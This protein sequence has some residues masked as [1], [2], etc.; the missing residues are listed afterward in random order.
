MTFIVSQDGWGR[1][2]LKIW[3]RKQRMAKKKTMLIVLFLSFTMSEA[4]KFPHWNINNVNVLQLFFKKILEDIS[5]FRGATDTPVLDF[6]WHLPWVS[7]LGWIP[8]LC[9]L[10]PVCNEFQRFTSGVTPA[11]CIEVSIAAEPFQSMYLQMCPQALVEAQGSNLWPS[12]L[13]AWHCR[14]LGHSGSTYVLQL[15]KEWVFLVVIF[16]PM[17]PS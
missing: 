10:S 4:K 12:M 5:P 9:A 17:I 6:W 14:P 2:H 7:K 11:D 8:H 13:Q 3:R 15:S 1:K 16:F